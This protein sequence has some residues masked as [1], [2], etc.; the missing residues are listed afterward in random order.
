MTH[1]NQLLKPR[2]EPWEP[3][4]RSG[5]PQAQ[6]VAWR[7]NNLVGPST[8][9]VEPVLTP[10]GSRGLSC[11]VPDG[12]LAVCIKSRHAGVWSVVSENSWESPWGTVPCWGSDLVKLPRNNL[13]FSWEA[14]GINRLW[15]WASIFPQ[16]FNFYLLKGFQ[17]Q[18]KQLRESNLYKILFDLTLDL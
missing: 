10:S 2:R 3:L 13:P 9:L 4:I 5:W 6:R 17:D 15:Q 16:Y 7:G 14:R 18:R 1:L 8:S 12:E 11:R